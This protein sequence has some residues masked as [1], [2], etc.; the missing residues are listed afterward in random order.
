MRFGGI[1]YRA[2]N[3]VW[4]ADPLSGEGA[5]RF[6][7]RFN[8]KGM[9]ALYT[10]LDPV[11]ALREVSQVGQ[12]LQPTLLI[13]FRA[14]VDPVFDACDAGL[15]AAQGLTQADLAADDWRVRPDPA[16]QVLARNLCA[17]GYAGLLGPSYARMAAAG[18][19][20]LVLWRW[21]PASLCLIDDDARLAG[22]ITPT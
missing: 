2:L 19:R 11:T 14:D 12:P 13:S 22:S 7:G 15:L 6:G 1:V 5:R 8:P 20:N 16:G 17:Q 9:A 4:V 18:A 21:T 10:T 3:P